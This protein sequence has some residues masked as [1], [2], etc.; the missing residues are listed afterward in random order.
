MKAEARRRFPPSTESFIVHDAN[1]QALLAYVYYEEE[2]GPPISCE[3]ADAQR[4]RRI[5]ANIA[6]L[7]DLRAGNI[8]SS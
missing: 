4:A 2:P 7:P 1:G 8:A 5:A 6:K 3:L